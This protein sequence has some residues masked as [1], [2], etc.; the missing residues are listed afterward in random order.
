MLPLFNGVAD[1][2]FVIPKDIS[3]GVYYFRAYTRWMLN[4]DDQFNFVEPINIYNTSSQTYLKKLAVAYDASIHVEGGQLVSEVPA[5][6]SVRLNAKGEL[7]SEWNGYL[8]EKSDSLEQ[9]VSFQNLNEEFASFRFVPFVGKKYALRITDNAGNISNLDLPDIAEDGIGIQLVNYGGDLLYNLISKK[10]S[11][12]GFKI[13]A[14]VQG[15]ILYNGIINADRKEVNGQIKLDSA[16]VGI[17]H[18]TLFDPEG[19]AISERLIFPNAEFIPVNK[20]SFEVKK[21]E[22][23][24]EL[25]I[26]SDSAFNATGIVELLDS[27]LPIKETGWNILCATYFGDL[28]RRPYKAASYFSINNDRTR[29]ALD[30]L[31][32]AEK[33]SRFSWGSL[34]DQ[35]SK[36]LMYPPDNY[37][38]FTGT[39]V[40]NRKLMTK[41]QINFWIQTITGMN[42]VSTKTDT[43]GVLK[44][45]G[46]VFYDTTK[47]FFKGNSDRAWAQDIEIS[48]QKNVSFRRYIPSLHATSF[49]TVTRTLSDTLPSI[50]KLYR[51]Q[52]DRETNENKKYKMMQE[53]VVKARKIDATRKL[54]DELSSGKF[55]SNNETVIDFVNNKQSINGSSN[56]IQWLQ[57]RVAGLTVSSNGGD[58]IP[59]LRGKQAY[60][61]FN[62]FPIDP[63]MALSIS[64]LDIAMIKII[65]NDALL[66]G[67]VI[68][69]YGLKGGMSNNIGE[70]TIPNNTLIGYSKPLVPPG[71]WKTNFQPGYSQQ[72]LTFNRVSPDEGYRVI[73]TGF[74]DRGYPVFIVKDL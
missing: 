25:I 14:Q 69:I 19:K 39:V 33:W 30:A 49:E 68:A 27:R 62:E 48:F 1:G 47:V 21:T 44:F 5:N 23:S 37:L 54:N 50:V 18:F 71:Y 8:F 15:E 11:L 57:G 17:I 70:S 10:S 6:I 67:G 3:E 53:V 74:N 73:V 55:Q 26:Q 40:R 59:Y 61:F 46:Q 66:G 43:T 72:K 22:D 12:K 29:K 4:W 28:V 45:E 64:P 65:R 16:C 56:I 41:A 7:P 9:L 51:E 63:S 58:F 38:Y 32:I 36:E 34:Q 13:L 60:I 52:L 42:I 2:S 35:L 20:P 31:M 24:L